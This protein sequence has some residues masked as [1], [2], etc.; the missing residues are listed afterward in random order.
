MASN[1]NQRRVVMDPVIHRKAKIACIEDETT[2]SDKANELFGDWLK[3]RSPK[4][5]I[6]PRY[7]KGEK[8]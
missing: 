4:S 8:V 7:R 5:P 1:N 6:K 2:L 3:S